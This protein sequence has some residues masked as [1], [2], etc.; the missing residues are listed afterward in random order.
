MMR[1]SLVVLWLCVL[2]PLT[3]HAQG[4]PGSDA[5][6]FI[7]ATEAWLAGD[8]DLSA[9]QALSA[10]ANEDNAAAQILLARIA[11][12]PHLYSYISESMTRADRIA[13]W[14]QPGGLSGRSWMQ[15]AAQ[16]S[17]L[18]RA[19]LDNNTPSERPMSLRVLFE[20]GETAAATRSL[21]TLFNYGDLAMLEALE[22]IDVMPAEARVF[23][24]SAL[25][26]NGVLIDGQPIRVFAP[27][28]Q[29]TPPELALIWNPLLPLDWSNNPLVRQFAL[30]HSINIASLSPLRDFCAQQCSGELAAC[31]AVGAS[32]GALGG[33]V[34]PFASPAESLISTTIYWESPRFEA[35][36][37]R[38][39]RRHGQNVQ[40]DAYRALNA[41]YVEQV[42]P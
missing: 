33:Y 19:F 8:D 26:I 42:A 4:I 18:A 24:V 15:A 12:T 6:E 34:F 1:A 11:A 37:L 16:S 38:L 41:C 25:Q 28:T 23:L 27:V 5:R 31:T 9:L 22:D 40:G 29:R 21:R 7:E 3:A 20:A 17:P 13:L 35:D 36:V 10:L 32:V 14:R 30:D 39:L 2:M